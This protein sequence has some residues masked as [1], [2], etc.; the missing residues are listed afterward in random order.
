MRKKP[1]VYG[2]SR[3]GLHTRKIEGQNVRREND[4]CCFSYRKRSMNM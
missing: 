3:K 1:A 2:F 4:A